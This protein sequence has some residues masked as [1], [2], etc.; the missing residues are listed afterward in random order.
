MGMRS[1]I[2]L[3]E[4]VL[5][6]TSSWVSG[7]LTSKLNLLTADCLINLRDIFVTY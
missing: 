5:L 6:M 1:M 7:I 4:L 3:S 2:N